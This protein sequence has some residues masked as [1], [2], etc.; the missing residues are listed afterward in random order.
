MTILSVRFIRRLSYEVFLYGHIFGTIALILALFYHSMWERA[1][2]WLYLTLI[3]WG[4]DRLFRICMT[5]SFY[6]L[7]G[8]VMHFGTLM[9]IDVLVPANIPVRPGQFAHLRFP[10]VRCLENHPFSIAA[11]TPIQ[12]KR[13][14]RDASTTTFSEVEWTPLISGGEEKTASARLQALTFLIRPFDGMTRTLSDHLISAASAIRTLDRPTPMKVYFEGAYGNEHDLRSYDSILFLAGGV[15]I[16]FTL[17]YLLKLNESYA[18]KSFQRIHF[19]WVTRALHEIESLVSFLDR[20]DDELREHVEIFYTGRIT[21]IGIL[22]DSALTPSHR[23]WVEQVKVG[24]PE[25]SNLLSSAVRD[26]ED[27]GSEPSSVAFLGEIIL[28]FWLSVP[29]SMLIR[30]M[31]CFTMGCF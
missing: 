29:C 30:T 8:R 23:Y 21:S 17:P 22:L 25:I 5:S 24:R 14:S 28:S 6:P 31:P 16:T 7:T 9:R 1:N 27:L 13:G 12:N 26:D 11:V 3:C 18:T 10:K 15:G 4:V 19:V 20:I 2:G